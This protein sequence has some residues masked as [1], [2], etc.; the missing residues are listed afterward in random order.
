MP[1]ISEEQLKKIM[2]KIGDLEKWKT[3]TEKRLSFLNSVTIEGRGKITLSGGH[4]KINSN[5]DTI[6]LS[7]P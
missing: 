7:K 5:V 2:D 3:S 6:S 1:Y 4:L